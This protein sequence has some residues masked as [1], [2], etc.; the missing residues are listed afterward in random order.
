MFV[1]ISQ[2]QVTISKPAGSGTEVV[3]G[4]IHGYGQLYAEDRQRGM[5]ALN[6]MLQL[7]D[8]NSLKGKILF[9]IVVVC[10]SIV[11]MRMLRTLHL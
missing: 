2:L 10:T 8:V 3:T 11:S 6:A 9:S 7:K 4:L 5:D 1:R